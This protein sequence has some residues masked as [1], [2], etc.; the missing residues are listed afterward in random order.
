MQNGALLLGT[1]PEVDRNSGRRLPAH[2][3]FGD[4][5]PPCVWQFGERLPKL[6]LDGGI[7][8]VDWA[9]WPRKLAP[10]SWGRLV[11]SLETIGS[12]RWRPGK[13]ARPAG[14]AILAF[15]TP[16]DGVGNN[17]RKPS[18]HLLVTMSR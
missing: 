5:R 1:E 2:I 8:R 12:N 14:H 18:L 13:P 4:D 16:K 15:F 9:P 7:G 10:V 3:A 17:T 11:W 6:S